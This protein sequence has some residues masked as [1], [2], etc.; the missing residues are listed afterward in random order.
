MLG[1]SFGPLSFGPHFR[2]SFCPL[3]AHIV[4]PRQL[5]QLQFLLFSEFQVLVVVL[6]VPLSDLPLTVLVDV[7]FYDHRTKKLLKPN[8]EEP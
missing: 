4:N 5:L 2:D 3:R 8:I 7:L 1:P 6:L